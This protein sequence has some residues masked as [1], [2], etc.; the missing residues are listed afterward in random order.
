MDDPTLP[1]GQALYDAIMG[2][3]EPDL[4]TAELPKLPEKFS[5]DT[6]EE[7]AARSERYKRAYEQYDL[8]FDELVEKPLKQV[9]TKRKNTMAFIENATGRKELNIIDDKLSAA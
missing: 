9:K 8:L 1:T 6:P 2:Q 3:I 4:V 7:K 5:K